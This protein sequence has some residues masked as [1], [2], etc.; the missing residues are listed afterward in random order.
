MCK[1]ACPACVYVYHVHA[2]CPWRSEGGIRSG[3]G[4]GDGCK[5]P[6]GCWDSNLGLLEDQPVCLTTELSTPLLPNSCCSPTKSS[7]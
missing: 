2:W 5:P 6:H 7:E 1:N 4:V 3:T